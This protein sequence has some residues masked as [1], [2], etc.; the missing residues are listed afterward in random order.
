MLAKAAACLPENFKAALR[1]LV[2]AYY[3]RSPALFEAVTRSARSIGR[4]LDPLQYDFTERMLVALLRTRIARRVERD[5]VAS[6]HPPHHSYNNYGAFVLGFYDDTVGAYPFYRG[7]FASLAIKEGDKVLD[8]SCGDGFFS[9]RFLAIKAAHVDAFD[10]EQDAI[11]MAN[12]Y[13]MDAKVSYSVRDA[14]TDPFPATDYDVIVWD[15]GIAHFPPGTNAAMVSKIKAALKMNG[16]FCGSETLGF[17]GSADHLQRWN[18]VD[19]VR[20]MLSPHFKHV[21]VFT[22][23]YFYNLQ[24]T[25]RRGEFY[26]RCSDSAEALAATEWI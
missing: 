18:T 13:N 6:N 11:A 16:T 15:G 26:W 2:R 7:F 1:P 19:D 23:E 12:R 9:K 25:G 14:T 21:K 5:W 10:I 24:R 3:R 4:S 20:A 22:A 17:D 8:I